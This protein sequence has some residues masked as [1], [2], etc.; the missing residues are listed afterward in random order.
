MSEPA[1]GG[2]VSDGEPAVPEPPDLLESTAIYLRDTASQSFDRFNELDESVWRSLPFFAAVFGFAATLIASVI[3]SLPRFDAPLF[4]FL[5]HSLLTLS[6]VSFAWA[7]RWFI[8]I[9]KRRSYEYP[10]E[11]REVRAYAERLT[12]YHAQ[13]G[14]KDTA[15]DA[16]VVHELILVEGIQLSDAAKQNGINARERLNARSLTLQF[17]MIGFGLA[18]ANSVTMFVYHR[19]YDIIPT[20][21][22][23]AVDDSTN[24]RKLEAAP[25]N[26]RNSVGTSNAATGERSD[27]GRGP[28]D[29]EQQ[30][31]SAQE[32]RIM[33]EQPA[34]SPPQP[35]SPPKPTAP[36]PQR[37]EK[38]A[39]P[40]P[41]NR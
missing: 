17:M 23:R 9:T 13:Q 12:A 22:E 7:F 6:V 19:V 33:V 8:A 35:A 1:I 32:G 30:G 4:A 28:L 34:P 37:L 26:E 41:Q 25:V 39:P 20:S 16:K 38:S 11:D 15:L 21:K 14:L 27:S 24:S 18:L 40:P 5:A 36:P 2:T 10:A 31:R 3:P 29:D